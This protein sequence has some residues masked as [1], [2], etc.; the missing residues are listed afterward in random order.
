MS[1]HMFR[2]TGKPNARKRSMKRR[3]SSFAVLVLSAMLCFGLC[4]PATV[5]AAPLK[6]EVIG[7]D[8][9]GNPWVADGT[10]DTDKE[11]IGSA[12]EGVEARTH[13]GVFTNPPAIVDSS[14]DFSGSIDDIL[15]IL[16]GGRS[17]A[18]GLS[19][20]LMAEISDAYSSLKYR[21]EVEDQHGNKT[22]IKEPAP[23]SEGVKQE[24]GNIIVSCKQEAIDFINDNR[25]AIEAAL[26]TSEYVEYI[27]R[28]VLC[29]EDGSDLNSE[30]SSKDITIRFLRSGSD[31]VNVDGTE[32]NPDGTPVNPGLVVTIPSDPTDPDNPDEIEITVSGSVHKNAKLIV[33][34]VKRS[35]DPN[36]WNGFQSG[37]E[38]LGD[39][40]VLGMYRIYMV[41]MKSDGTQDTVTN[42]F[43][44][45]IDVYMRHKGAGSA[46]EWQ[47]ADGVLFMQDNGDGTNTISSLPLTKALNKDWAYFTTDSLGYFAFIGSNGSNNPGGDGTKHQVTVRVG[48]HGTVTEVPDGVR[49]YNV[50]DG[51]TLQLQVRADDHYKVKV[52]TTSDTRLPVKWSDDTIVIGPVKTSGTVDVSFEYVSYGPDDP[53]YPNGPDGP[54]DPNNPNNPYDPDSP[55]NP[56]NPEN[57]NY[58]PNPKVTA[59]IENGSLGNGSV[60]VV[61]SGMAGLIGN[62]SEVNVTRG[63]P[64]QVIISPN[65]GRKVKDVRVEPATGGYSG[66]SW[67]GN[68]LHFSAVDRN[69]TVYV[70][71]EVG[72][73]LTPTTWNVALTWNPKEGGSITGASTNIPT[74][75]SGVF[76]I[77]AKD[78]YTVDSS[79]IDGVDAK[80]QLVYKGD[81]VWTCTIA[82]NSKQTRAFHV[83][84]VKGE[85]PANPDGNNPGGDPNNPGGDPN[86][87]GGDTPVGS[88]FTVDLSIAGSGHVWA[89]VSNNGMIEGV[90]DLN[91]VA[92]LLPVQRVAAA[93]PLV[94]V[95]QSESG[96]LRGSAEATL[97]DGAYLS[98]ASDVYST[99][100]KLHLTPK[101][102]VTF[103]LLPRNG[104]HIESV[105]KNGADAGVGDTHVLTHTASGDDDHQSL[106]VNFKP[107][108]ISD[109]M[110]NDY[111]NGQGG[112]GNGNGNGADG[113][114][115]GNG[116]GGLLS[117]TGSGNGG[118]GADGSGNVSGVKTP[119]NVGSSLGKTGDIMWMIALALL[120]MAIVAAAVIFVGRRKSAQSSGAGSGIESG[121]E[122]IPDTLNSTSSIDP[123]EDD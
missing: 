100:T 111:L 81:G 11:H 34:K 62:T 69:I 64:A 1:I 105:A 94:N 110:I 58:V 101:S 43:V 75:Q 56:N 44:S 63:D 71:F 39:Y 54:K 123:K 31:Y 86:K 57:P 32:T 24:N 16:G 36:R 21:W 26:K 102:T 67:V 121:S 13:V 117:G 40:S 30:N 80:S 19:G 66:M 50:V 83:E 90:E 41:V 93:T 52:K 3:F 68:A 46:G 88:E 14:E 96:S 17:R 45:S 122:S 22:R 61:G 49:A 103:V 118:T 85:R 55:D 51:S 87:P 98:R 59:V 109:D 114:G 73:S 7:F 18:A 72:S 28:C 79:N 38:A 6:G 84:F 47:Y 53:N 78:G 107:G 25:A 89:V 115:S 42:A 2:D 12:D 76:T 92:R 23:V 112:N 8:S 9:Y 29:R 15:G 113:D 104:N 37:A 106:A 120:A 91:T 82:Y 33:E 20:G 119:T 97:A 74:S 65:A 10:V 27:F 48:T 70:S 35:E 4:M 116:S 108:E 99:S 60:Q 5:L 95:S 77:H